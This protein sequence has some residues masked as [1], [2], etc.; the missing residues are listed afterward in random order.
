MFY[1]LIYFIGINV[2]TVFNYYADKQ[3]A[4]NGGWRIP[5]AN[6]LFF[7][8]IGGSPGALL[9]THLFR[10]KRR[11]NSFMD[12]LYIIIGLQIVLASFELTGI[13]SIKSFFA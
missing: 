5:E 8:L 7:A 3:A 13:L 10:H 9:S 6:L 4:I 2:F 11:K 1:A 12:V